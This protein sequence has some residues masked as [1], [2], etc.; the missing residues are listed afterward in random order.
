MRI[1]QIISPLFLLTLFILAGGSASHFVFA[2]ETLGEVEQEK[3]QLQQQ[4]QQIQKKISVYQK[5][6]ASVS[7]EK[8]TLQT[9]MKILHN[10]QATLALN[11]EALSLEVED[12][13]EQVL[14][15]QLTI[16]E[17]EMKLNTIKSQI[18]EYL[19]EMRENDERNM[20]F[21]LF[22][23]H[24][25]FDVLTELQSYTQVATGLNLLSEELHKDNEELNEQ[26]RY[27]DEKESR[28]QEYLTLRLLQE[29]AL[30]GSLSEQSVL[31]SKTKG[32]ESNYQAVLT[33]SKKQASQI[34]S[35]L[36]QLLDVGKQITFGQ[37]VKIAQQVSEST[38]VRASFLLAILTQESNLG[39]NVGT[40]NRSGDPPSKSW[41]VIMKPTRD[42]EPFK[43]ITAELGRNPDITPVSCPMKDKQGNQIGWG[44]AMGPA[45]FI[46]STW[47]GY[48]D[49][50]TK[51]TGLPA[52]PWEIRDAFIAAALK[53]GN[54]GATTQEGEWAAAMKYFSGSTNVRFRFYGDN[55]IKTAD[56]Y[57]K[58][59]EALKK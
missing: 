48:K 15:N 22:S 32:L 2:Q 47:M 49:K 7:K 53:L 17:N 42:Q 46:P 5:E 18:A 21:V 3:T 9:R 30:N 10:E 40:C 4:L 59:I 27:L 58:D 50:I 1:K 55:V 36:Y 12:L 31:L 8:Q 29:E 43:T 23:K 20:L 33:D 54:D 57:E 6:L 13:N 56:Q 45:Q 28:I 34:Q 41:K 26:K 14:E 11:I 16:Q 35:R 39:K 25:L 38:G 52:D 37:A 44:G 51:I 24:S 19:R